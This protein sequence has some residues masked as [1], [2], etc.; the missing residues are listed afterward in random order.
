MR[1]FLSR[2]AELLTWKTGAE[3]AAKGIVGF[4]A[5]VL[6]LC[7]V[8]LG[9]GEGSLCIMEG[10]CTMAKN[11]QGTYYHRNEYVRTSH[12]TRI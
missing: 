12:D 6:G 5:F 8:G 2:L 7:A 1:E 9:L 3:V 10:Q 4:G 11:T